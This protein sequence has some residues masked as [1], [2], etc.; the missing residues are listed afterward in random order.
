MFE[1]LLFSVCNNIEDR[2]N[3][4]T[5]EWNSMECGLVLFELSKQSME[6]FIHNV[7]LSYLQAPNLD[8]SSRLYHSRETVT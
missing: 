6:H 4:L 8:F 5:I 3:M 7:P 1:I 2:M